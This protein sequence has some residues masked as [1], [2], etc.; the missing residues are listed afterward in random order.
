ME[1]HNVCLDD[2]LIRLK[3]VRLLDEYRVNYFTYNRIS[4]LWHKHGETDCGK[5]YGI[6]SAFST[7][8]GKS[9]RYA[10]IKAM[11]HTGSGEALLV[12]YTF[13][14]WVSCFLFHDG[15]SLHVVPFLNPLMESGR[16]FAC[17]CAYHRCFPS[18]F[19]DFQGCP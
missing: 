4:H 18:L 1:G 12:I 14:R 9:T 16:L 15:V 7:F 10:M 6:K 2:V 19:V 8:L 13:L 5:N 17:P 11:P 3:S